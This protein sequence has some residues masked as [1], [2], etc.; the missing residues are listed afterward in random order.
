M[1]ARCSD[2]HVV[3]GGASAGW[4]VCP[5]TRG[6]VKSTSHAR[7]SRKHAC[8]VGKRW[9]ARKEEKVGRKG[10][11]RVNKFWGEGTLSLS[12]SLT[13]AVDRGFSGMAPATIAMLRYRRETRLSLP[14][15]PRHP[16]PPPALARASP[17]T[18]TKTSHVFSPPTLTEGRESGLHA[19]SGQHAPRRLEWVVIRS[20]QS[21]TRHRSP[22]TGDARHKH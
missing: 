17:T 2:A 16:S 1:P 15:C 18:R 20:P 7:I 8:R 9:N 21:G 13:S 10:E 14:C 19:R 3:E 4:C 6:C 5:L 22:R 11:N 12:L